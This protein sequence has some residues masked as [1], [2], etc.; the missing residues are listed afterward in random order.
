MSSRAVI[1]ALLGIGLVGVPAPPAT[2][3]TAAEPLGIA[4][5]GYAY[6]HPVRYL[7]LIV[8]RHA[9][10]L[11]YMDVAPTAAP[12]GR[13]ILLLHGRNFPASYWAPT[14]TA[15]T[16]AGFR[17]IAPDQINFGKSSKLDDVP[18]SFDAM[19]LH[20][21]A[22]LDA[23]GV[24]RADVVAH[25]MGNMAG[26]RF[27]R[28]YPERVGRLAL[29]APVGLEDYRFTVPPVP[30]ERLIEQ[31]ERLSGEAYLDQLITTY[32]LTL[33][34]EQV[35]PF[36]DLRERL[37][38]SAEWPRWVRSFVSSYYAIWGQP[39][40]HELPLLDKPVLFL[41]GT[42]DRTAPGRPFARPED[43]E[44][45]GRVAER[46][47]ELAPRMR[48]ARVETFEGVG[49]LI[50]MEAPERFHRALLAFLGG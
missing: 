26:V 40:V 16:G 4:L 31:E 34:R 42:R 13:T 20:M 21:V 2:A 5:E 18:V 17:V 38:G 9:V 7:P 1:A 10:R 47:R 27:A 6:P 22:L 8:G 28:T 15:L 12:N 49:H 14:I 32:G 39:V 44:R 25:S 30:E 29:Y 45:M 37:K 36:A 35:Q 3:Q 43:R 48:E 46:A 33:P 23:L 41:V 24:E 50:H 11:A 19:A